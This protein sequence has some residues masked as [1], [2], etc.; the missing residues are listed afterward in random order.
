MNY[1]KLSTLTVSSIHIYSIYLYQRILLG[2]FFLGGGGVSFFRS[3]ENK[4]HSFGDVI[5]AGEG[6]KFWP[7]LGTHG[8]WAMGFF[9]VPHLL[10][11]RPTLYNGHLWGPGTLTAAFGSGKLNKWNCQ[12]I[13][14]KATNAYGDTGRRTDDEWKEIRIVLNLLILLLL[15]IY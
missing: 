1:P 3:T 4:F 10:W 6:Y 12:S 8:H 13:H 15:E 9:D 5:T 11:H 14:F 7:I 2:G